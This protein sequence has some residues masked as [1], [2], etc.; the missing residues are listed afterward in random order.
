MNQSDLLG[1]FTETE[2]RA[3]F[4][5]VENKEHWKKPIAAL[6]QVV[7]ERELEAIKYAVTFYTGSV[8]TVSRGFG[9]DVYKVTAAGYYAAVGA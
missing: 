5:R 9:P 7:S 8:A 4:S 2:L 6:V 3:A 1:G